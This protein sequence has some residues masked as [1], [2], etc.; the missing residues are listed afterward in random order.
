MEAFLDDSRIVGKKKH[1][2]HNRIYP[3]PDETTTTQTDHLIMTHPMWRTAQH[4]AVSGSALCEAKW[5]ILWTAPGAE[6]RDSR[7]GNSNRLFD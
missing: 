3:L 5:L 1:S 7:P 6:M 4:S 2:S